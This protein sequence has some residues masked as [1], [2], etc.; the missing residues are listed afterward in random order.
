MKLTP[1]MVQILDMLNDADGFPV[2]CT[3]ERSMVAAEALR[4]HGLVKIEGR[5]VPRFPDNGR[6]IYTLQQE[7]L[8]VCAYYVTFTDAGRETY[9]AGNV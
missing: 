1:L 9:G 7:Q 4:E 8:R 6:A 3:T 2:V 5:M